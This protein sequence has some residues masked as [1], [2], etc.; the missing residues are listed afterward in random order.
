M[1]VIKDIMK[2]TS[3]KENSYNVQSEM[4]ILN[5][6]FDSTP[7]D[8]LKNFG[9]ETDLPNDF[10]YEDLDKLPGIWNKIKH[11]IAKNEIFD[12]EAKKSIANSDLKDLGFQKVTYLID[13]NEDYQAILNTLKEQKTNALLRAV[14]EN[15]EER[16]ITVYASRFGVWKECD[17]GFSIPTITRISKIINGGDKGLQ[18]RI[19]LTLKY[20]EYI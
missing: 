9:I 13:D 19:Q 2:S 17:R 16:E 18:E 10:K 20:A 8:F 1:Q 3:D 7:K 4:K 14:V 5:I 11:E 6:A 15:Q 12:A